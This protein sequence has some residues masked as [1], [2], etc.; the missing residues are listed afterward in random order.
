MSDLRKRL[1]AITVAITFLFCLFLARFFY[2]PVSWQDDL[3][4]RPLD[5]C[6]RE[7]PLSAVR[8]LIYRRHA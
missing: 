8:G 5:H 3:I 1:S 2:I 7:I 6:T 4:A